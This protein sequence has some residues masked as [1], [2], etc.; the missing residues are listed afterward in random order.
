MDTFRN[1]VLKAW[2]LKII[3]ILLVIH[4]GKL[5]GITLIIISRVKLYCSYTDSY[6]NAQLLLT[7]KYVFLKLHA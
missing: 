6:R 2:R 5:H 3:A 4:T 7:G 1:L